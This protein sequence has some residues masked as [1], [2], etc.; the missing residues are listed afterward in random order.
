MLDLTLMGPSFSSQL[1]K[2][3]GTF[4]L[5]TEHATVDSAS[6]FLKRKEVVIVMFGFVYC[7]Y[8]EMHHSYCDVVSLPMVLNVDVNNRNFYYFYQ[9][10]LN[11]LV[12][13]SSHLTPVCRFWYSN[14]DRCLL[15]SCRLD[16]RHV[17][18]GKVISGLD[19]V[20]K[21]EAEGTQQGTPKRK[22]TVAESGELPL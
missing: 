15:V 18:F 1:W 13:T 2:Q 17:V 7:R 3:A 5:A 6:V 14:I 20:Y 9:F 10:K 12:H 21:V 16:G 8:S 4:S 11:G 19:V 22:V